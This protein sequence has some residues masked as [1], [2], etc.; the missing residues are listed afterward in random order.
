MEAEM[1]FAE[2]TNERKRIAR[3]RAS[4]RKQAIIAAE[5]EAEIDA[6]NMDRMPDDIPDPRG[7]DPYPK[8]TGKINIRC[9]CER[10]VC[11]KATLYDLAKL[12]VG[13]NCPQCYRQ[14]LLVGL[15]EVL[16]ARGG[17]LVGVYKDATKP[18]TIECS[19]GHTFTAIPDRVRRRAKW[20]PECV[21]PRVSKAAHAFEMAVA[22]LGGILITPYDRSYI[23]VT[24]Q[25]RAGHQWDTTPTLFN[26]HGRWCPECARTTGTTMKGE[27]RKAPEKVKA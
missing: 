15:E 24:L 25:C 6:R 27:P 20:C 14:E 26:Q 17:K 8:R 19:E 11:F 7:L 13:E 9:G 21:Q 22:E 3:A 5:W 12:P 18:V 16:T 2:E 23:S 10:Q 1:N 4:A